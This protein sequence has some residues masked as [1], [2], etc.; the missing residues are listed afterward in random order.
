MPITLKGLS[1]AICTALSLS[2]VSN[3]TAIARSCM[4]NGQKK[5]DLVILTQ[6][7]HISASG[8]CVIGQPLVSGSVV[9][10]NIGEAIAWPKGTKMLRVYSLDNPKLKDDDR[11]LKVLRP[12][13]TMKIKVNAGRA[14]LRK[15]IAG[16]HRIMIEIDP[17][18]QIQECRKANNTW[19][20]AI[21]ITINC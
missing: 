8:K 3:S 10:K 9:I 21:P 5:P 16:R 19:F 14:V 13:E 6:G 2:I 4:V 20:R 1:L 12:G 18:N 15:D 7:T 17:D 11:K